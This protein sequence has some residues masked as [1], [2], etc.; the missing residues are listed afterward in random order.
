MRPRDAVTSRPPSRQTEPGA[1]LGPGSRST[2]QPATSADHARADVSNR[3]SKQPATPAAKPKSAGII[4]R[5][6]GVRVPPP[7]SKSLH[8]RRFCG[9]LEHAE[10]IPLLRKPRYIAIA[11][12]PSA[13][14]RNRNASSGARRTHLDIAVVSLLL[15]QARAAALRG[16][17]DVVVVED[18]VDLELAAECFDIALESREAD[19]ELLLDPPDIGPRGR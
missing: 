19:V 15:P 10:C 6:S 9:W 8:R 2:A 17:L 12:R 5:V 1:A 7:A 14:A 13:F 18:G 11:L 16:Q 4:I 3:V